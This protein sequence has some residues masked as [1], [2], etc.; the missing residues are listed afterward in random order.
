MANILL[1]V[2]TNT[3]LNVNKESTLNDVHPFCSP[4]NGNCSIKN[5]KYYN[6][7]IASKKVSF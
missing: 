2:L 1:E 7:T 3:S 5:T 6:T 4:G